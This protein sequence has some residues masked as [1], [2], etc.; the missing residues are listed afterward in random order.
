MERNV[1]F[2][3]SE[4]SKSVLIQLAEDDVFPEANKTFQV[5]IRASPG[6]Y[7][8]PNAY[9]TAMILNDDAELRG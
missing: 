3:S 5:Y 2:S 6:V 8:S 7:I 4:V 9:V 1:T